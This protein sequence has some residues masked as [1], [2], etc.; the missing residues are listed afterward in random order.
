MLESADG[1]LLAVFS[2]VVRHG[3]FSGAAETLRVS[4]SVVSE[5]IRRLEERCGSRL[6]ER[7]TRRLRLTEAGTQVLETATRIEDALGA[8][9]RNLDERRSEPSGVLRVSTT[10]DL[11]P[12]LVAPVVARFVTAYPNVRVEVLADDARQELLETKVDVAVRLG[13]AQSSSFVARKLAVLNEPI[14]ATPSLAGRLGAVSRPRGLSGAPWVKHSLLGGNTLTFKG[15]NREREAITPSF[16]AEANSGSTLLSLLLHGAGV[17]FFP[18]HALREHL[19][20][21]RLVVLCPGW[22]WRQVTLFALVPSRASVTAAHKAFLVMLQEQL[23]LDRT[24]WTVG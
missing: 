10:N 6:L 18:E 4:K 12:L 5:R 16:R 9:S 24:R 23:Q 7:T 2:A 1:A 15:P 19:H 14:V 22:V 17:G 3:S 13:T 20:S 8:L 11:G 21:G